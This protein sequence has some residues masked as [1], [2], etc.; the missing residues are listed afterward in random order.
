MDA[1]RLP[2]L[3]WLRTFEASAR[4]M[5]FTQAAGELNITQAAVSQQVC[6]L[7]TYLGTALFNRK[8]QGLEITEQGLAYLP[9][10]QEAIMRLAKTTDEL[11]ATPAKNRI[12]VNAS[13]VYLTEC[14]AGRVGEF[15]DKHPNL[16]LQF[17]SNLYDN[18]I[19]QSA[20][21]AIL[22][23][24]GK[25][26]GY[27]CKRLTWD[28]IFAVCS[29]EIA[30]KAKKSSLREFLSNVPLLH[31]IGYEEGWGYWLNQIGIENIDYSKG[32]QTDTLISSFR[33]A[34]M[35]HGVV[36]ARSSLVQ[37]RL[38]SGTLVAPFPDFTQA[39][40]A[41]YFAK[42]QHKKPSALLTAFQNWLLSRVD[43]KR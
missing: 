4:H 34:E 25:W 23:G 40:D 11:F 32:I 2:P 9:S 3:N 16:S 1:K 27:K 29:P 7:E 43:K 21:C 37:S 10:V 41:F 15:T 12:I 17:V 14:L 8:P 5:N 24:N 26:P 22:V 31:V 6:K 30:A 28:K 33:L 36:L 39:N 35:G 13:I 38:E 18:Q 20:D 19:K 42:P